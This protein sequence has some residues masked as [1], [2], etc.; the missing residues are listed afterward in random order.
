MAE[1]PLPASPYGQQTCACRSRRGRD[2]LASCEQR[3][4]RSTP[5]RFPARV[6]FAARSYGCR[7]LCYL[8]PTHPYCSVDGVFAAREAARASVTGWHATTSKKYWSSCY[9]IAEHDDGTILFCFG[10]EPAKEKE[11]V[12]AQPDVEQQTKVSIPEQ[13]AVTTA[14]QDEEEPAQSVDK[15]RELTPSEEP[16]ENQLSSDGTQ[17]TIS[18]QIQQTASPQSEQAQPDISM[19][20]AD[21]SDEEASASDSNSERLWDMTPQQLEGLK[22]CHRPMV[23]TCTL[24]PLRSDV[25]NSQY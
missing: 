21:T 24:V 4:Y 22:V 5:T 16:Q 23:V 1:N 2:L 6:N 10:E 17:Q 15:A 14:Q 20:S 7:A 3:R 12:A 9:C 13:Q 18:S 25:K 11:A 19:S 8:T